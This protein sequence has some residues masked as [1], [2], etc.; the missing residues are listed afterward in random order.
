MKQFREYLKKIGSGPH[1]GKHLTRE[2]AASAMRMMLTA[3]ATPAQIGAFL[4][5]H[6]M[7]RPTGEELAGF[8]DTYDKMAIELE[9]IDRVVTVLGCPYDGRSRTTP[10]TPIVALTL[11][12]LGLGVV[13]HGGDRMPTK[14]GIPTIDIWRGLGIDWTQRSIDL[15][16]KVFEKTGLGFVY[17]PQWFSEAY[18]L[19][20]YRDQIGKRP[21]VATLELMWSPYR[22]RT[23]IVSGFVHPPTENL[24]RDA[25]ALRGETLFTTVKGLE[26]SCDLPRSRT[27]IIGCF[28]TFGDRGEPTWKRLHLHPREYG[29]AGSDVPFESDEQV[30]SDL[31]DVIAGK[32]TELTQSAIWNA[33]F[34]L[35]RTGLSEDLNAAIALAK[36]TIL[37]GSIAMKLKELQQVAET[38][39]S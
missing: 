24:F 34:Y 18:R 7:Q 14:Y 25:F 29:F 9:A 1:T 10:V 15:V 2:D 27:A 30:I 4:I 8:L 38:A 17:P 26:G 37:D 32:E 19:V 33:G 11:A 5:A 36:R 23:H 16:Q 3:E 13:M 31:Q 28:G 35:W 39:V 20:E 6:R 21:P 12:A 22:G